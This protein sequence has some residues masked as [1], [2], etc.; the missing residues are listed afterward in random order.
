MN[1]SSTHLPSH[2]SGINLQIAN[3]EPNAVAGHV[4]KMTECLI[5]L[6]IS[7]YIFSVKKKK[8]SG[9]GI[10]FPLCYS[11][12]LALIQHCL[13]CLICYCVRMNFRFPSIGV[14]VW[15][16]WISDIIFTVMPTHFFIMW[17]KPVSSALCNLKVLNHQYLLEN[18]IH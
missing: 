16:I 17:I 1:N 7:L 15:L 12:I 8:N 14:F 6:F 3:N 9:F 5:H 4:K 11:E 2:R 18:S 13:L 10:D